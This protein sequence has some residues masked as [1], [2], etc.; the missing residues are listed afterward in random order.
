MKNIVILVYFLF[1]FTYAQ[2]TL[3]GKIV[4]NGNVLENIEVINTTKK[5]YSKSD[6]K[7]FFNIEAEVNDEIVFYR[8]GY[9][10]KYLKVGQSH[11][12]GN[13][14]TIRLEQSA[15]ELEEVEVTAQKKIKIDMGYDALTQ[16]KI[17]KEARS[18]KVVGVNT[19]GIP[20]GMDFV[21]IGKKVANLF[22]NKDKKEAKTKA[23]LKT[24]IKKNLS[25]SFFVK[26][27]NLPQDKIPE[28]IEYCENDEASAIVLKKNGILDV[29][30]FLMKKRK[31]FY[32]Q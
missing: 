24:Y 6:A 4:N 18:P 32:L 19:G 21:G 7:G 29:M 15:I 31:E 16:T 5:K 14:L 26:D 2:T 30:E 8:K 12:S 22:K 1:S 20:N 13:D 27:L 3:K 9:I 11:F 23:S 10:Q 17:E 25:E 28:F